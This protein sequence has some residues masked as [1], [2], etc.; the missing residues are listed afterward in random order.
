MSKNKTKLILAKE[1][2]QMLKTIPMGKIRVSE[3]CRR[4]KVLPATFYYHFHDKYDLVSWIFLYDLYQALPVDYLEFN[5]KNLCSIYQNFSNRK[6]FYKQVL[7]DLSQNSL[8]YY[9]QYF[10][11]TIAKDAFI[12][13]EKRISDYTTVSIKFYSYGI[14]GLIYEW[15]RLNENVSESVFIESCN[16]LIPEFVRSIFKDYPTQRLWNTIKKREPL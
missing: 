16:T 7:S 9:L 14:I 13:A 3:L 12:Y 15:I 10:I 4:S 6:W 2:E 5:T 8:S 1:L 11:E